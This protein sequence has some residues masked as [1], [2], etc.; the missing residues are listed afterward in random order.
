MSK[1]RGNVVDPFDLI[2]KTGSDAVRW[3]FYTT[4]TV[5]LEYRISVQRVAESAL[6]FLNVL[7]NTHSFLVTY[8][9]LAGWEPSASSPALA[10]RHPLDR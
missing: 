6:R 1:S 2:S 10:E 5:G 7:W 8:A 9:N 4:V 3:W